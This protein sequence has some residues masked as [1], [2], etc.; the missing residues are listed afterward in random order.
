MNYPNAV[1]KA[2]NEWWRLS[3]EEGIDE[4]QNPRDTIRWIESKAAD[5]MLED[6]VKS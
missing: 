5:Y 1:V 2:M 3:E 6:D 4:Y